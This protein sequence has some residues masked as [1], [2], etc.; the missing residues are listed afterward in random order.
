MPAPT[1]TSC[2]LKLRCPFAC[3][4][5]DVGAPSGRKHAE[6]VVKRR[7]V[8]LQENRRV[9]AQRARRSHDIARRGA[10]LAA[11]AAAHGVRKG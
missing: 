7:A 8:G 11:P 3:P 2:S 9:W 5:G 6:G 4:Q 1:L 10:E